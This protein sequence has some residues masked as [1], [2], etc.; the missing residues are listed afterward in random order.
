MKRLALPVM[1]L[2]LA[3]IT[4]NGCKKEDPIDSET[5]TATDNSLCEG[6]FMRIL[7]TVNKIAIDEPGVQ[8]IIPGSATASTCPVI[9]IDTPNQFP[10]T[11]T[12]DY[13]AGCTDSIDGK[14]RKGKV[15]VNMSAP[16]DTVGCVMTVTLDSFY[17]GAIHFMGSITYTRT[18]QNRYTMEINNGH[19]HRA[20][21]TPWDI[22]WNA[23]R[24]IDWVSG[25][26]NSQDNQVVQISGSNSGIDRN[27]L[28][29]TST[30]TSPL[31]RELNCNWINKG[32]IVITPEGKPER[33]VDF[34]DGT[35]DNKGT[36]TIEG[37]YFEFTMN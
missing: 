28:R 14:V 7:P 32:T 8:R 35:C 20:G 23:T 27:G 5:T 16:W 18:T 10:L 26:T 3:V 25:S 11:M 22:F 37:N 31:V 33:K 15:H 24:T 6:E 29:W 9:L 36:I 13:G 12:L 30:I 34:G 1:L 2:G 17:V 4:L 19:C 21:A